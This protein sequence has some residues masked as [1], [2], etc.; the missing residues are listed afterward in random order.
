MQLKEINKVCGGKYSGRYDVLYET[1]NGNI[2]NYEMISRDTNMTTESIQNQNKFADAVSI[3][4]FNEDFTKV[5]LNKEFRMT[6]NGL[7]YGLP[8]GLIDDGETPEE[9]AIRELLEETGL[10]VTR[11]ISVLPG[12]YSAVGISNERTALV[13]CTVDGEPQNTYEE[14]EEIEPIWVS[15]D[16]ILPIISSEIMCSRAQIFLYMWYMKDLLI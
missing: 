14:T 15:K 4:A 12:A 2:K 11:I 6:V 13:V 10:R 7:T 9:A 5:C 3:I 8:A 1:E 16:D